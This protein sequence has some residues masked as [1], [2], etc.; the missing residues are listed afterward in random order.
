MEGVLA[1]IIIIVARMTLS[2]IANLIQGDIED[3]R[4]AHR[5]IRQA[6]NIKCQF[7]DIRKT[8]DNSSLYIAKVLVSG[9]LVVPRD[10]QPVQWIVTIH[11]VT[12]GEDSPMPLFC[13]IGELADENRCYKYTIE[14]HI[15]YVLSE[16]SDLNL[17]AVPLFALRGPNRGKRKYRI[18]VQLKDRYD[19]D[20]C[21]SHGSILISYEQQ[22]L[23]YTEL[24]EHSIKQEECIASLGLAMAAVDG[25]ISKRETTIINGYFSDRYFH[26]DDPR[27][28]NP[29][30][31][32]TLQR[33]MKLLQQGHN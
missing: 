11:D 22:E 10:N 1:I 6:L 16:I 17:T 23:G 30:V 2:I 27:E 9:E 14:S 3:M 33:T 21:F 19:S 31:S 12:N 29:R 8:G 13:E 15:P 18:H 4:A 28:R 26:L 20:L 32:S 7:E 5:R 25:R 24:K